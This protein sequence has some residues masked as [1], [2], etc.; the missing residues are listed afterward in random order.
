MTVAV[1]K[2]TPSGVEALLQSV[3]GKA[4]VTHRGHLKQSGDEKSLPDETSQN[5][6]PRETDTSEPRVDKTEKAAKREHGDAKS[7]DDS[8]FEDTFDSMGQDQTD[9][10]GAKPTGAT[11]LPTDTALAS[12]AASNAPALPLDKT[13]TAESQTQSVSR[14]T[15][16]LPQKS[17]LALMSA[18]ERLF[19]NDG[20][21][22]AQPSTDDTSSDQLPVTSDEESEATPI[23]VDRRETHW[24]FADTALTATTSKLAA[25]QADAPMILQASA[26]KANVSKDQISVGKPT[27]DAEVKAATQSMTLPQSVQMPNSAFADSGG[28]NNPGTQNQSQTPVLPPEHKLEKADPSSTLDKIFSLNS[29]LQ[30]SS[31]G[32]TNQVR[33]GVIAGLATAN[34]DAG[35]SASTVDL[36]ARS[37]AAPVMKTLDLTLSPP[38]LGAV[39]LRLSLKS[40][41]L[42]IEA[43]ASKASTAKLLIDD[44]QNLERGLKDAGYDISSMK[45]TDASASGSSNSSGWQANG[46][47]TRDGDQARSGFSGRQDGEMQR[48]DGSSS[49]QARQRQKQS[50]PQSMPVDVGIAGSGNAVYI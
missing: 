38:D 21:L 32:V 40:N 22:K 26:A 42:S 17:I 16:L 9:G 7:D 36:P 30:P 31:A 39:K 1:G 35:N 3:S 23:T 15:S 6:S 29:N 14:P 41:S 25:L 43:E 13:T 8:S 10:A 48:R 24:N 5:S 37:T 18:K 49:D 2:A 45:I 34:A 27:G 44:R 28:G 47:Q 4:T 50:D 33:D 11:S 20:E 12:I 46:S 19:T